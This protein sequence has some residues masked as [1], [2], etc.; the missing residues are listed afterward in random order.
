MLIQS[1]NIGCPNSNLAQ[2]VS[3]FGMSVGLG[4]PQSCYSSFTGN[5]TYAS[6]FSGITPGNVCTAAPGA[7][8]A[9]SPSELI[10]WMGDYGGMA[11]RCV[12]NQGGV[13]LI[14]DINLW[15]NTYITYGSNN[16]ELLLNVFAWLANPPCKPTETAEAPAPEKKFGVSPNPAEDFLMVSLPSGVD[17]AALYDISGTAVMRIGD[18]KNDI[19]HL[20]PGVYLL[21]A[22]KRVRR[23]IKL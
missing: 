17:E 1:E 10:G 3:R 23:V 21:R 13:I 8:G 6:I 20:R 9:S 19:R 18:G 2:V 15:D 7:V 11:G 4:D 16:D 5:P 14:S 12:N 22:G